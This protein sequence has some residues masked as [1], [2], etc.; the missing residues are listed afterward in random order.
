MSGGAVGS[1]FGR[2]DDPSAL[3]RLKV[4]ASAW[5]F[6]Q[7]STPTGYEAATAVGSPILPLTRSLNSLEIKDES[8]FRYEFLWD[9]TGE[10]TNGLLDT[11]VIPP[12]SIPRLNYFS[13]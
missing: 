7:N 3:L 11:W 2:Y 13:Q 1:I 10:T 8:V 9:L 4:T 6:D 5:L 12:G